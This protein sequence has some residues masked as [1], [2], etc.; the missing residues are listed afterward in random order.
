VATSFAE[1]GLIC[2]NPQCV[3]PVEHLL[4]KDS[5]AVLED[6]SISFIPKEDFLEV[7]Q[8]SPQFA[9]SL[10]KALSHEFTVFA[11]NISA[12]S[13]ASAAERLA[14]ALI[15]FREKSKPGLRYG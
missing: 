13:D 11:N 1:R 4:V 2:N 14:I 15:V 3:C 9:I 8:R 10:L 5:A 6:S 7:L 12:F